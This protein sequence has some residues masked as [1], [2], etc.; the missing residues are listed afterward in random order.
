MKR[1]YY[2]SDDLDDLAN[3]EQEL[4]AAGI[5]QPQIH[6]FS[7]DDVGIER[8]K[9]HSVQDF[10]KRD[11][12]HSALLGSIVGLVA[13]SLVLVVVYFSGVTTSVGWVPF[14]LLAVVILGF[15]TWEGGL[16]GMHVPHHGLRHF[17]SAIHDGKHV[18]FVDLEPEQTHLLSHIQTRHPKLLHA[19]E[20]DSTPGWAISFQKKWRE[21]IHAMP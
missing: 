2:I 16:F 18:L 3:V 1:F 6:V 13:A 17:E 4:E 5:A 11:V 21:F 10:M 9:L 12:V 15:C 7:G 8:R 19:G 20:G 14:L